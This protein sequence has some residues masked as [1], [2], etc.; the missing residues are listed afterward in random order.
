MKTR[1][2]ISSYLALAALVLILTGGGYVPGPRP[3]NEDTDT[4]PNWFGQT[5]I[6]STSRTSAHYDEGRAEWLHSPYVV[7]FSANGSLQTGF[8]R[9]AF[10]GTD[11]SGAGVSGQASAGLG[12]PQASRCIGYWAN[13]SNTFGVASG[14]T[15]KVWT[16]KSDN[17]AAVL[18]ASFAIGEGVKTYPESTF[19]VAADDIMSVSLVAGAGNVTNPLVEFRIFPADTIP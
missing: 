8:L 4:P 12:F 18:K 3:V 1:P 11:T 10:A 17:S 6:D 16:T 7:R 19:T 14:C 13:C 9:A 2:P 5:W 15:V